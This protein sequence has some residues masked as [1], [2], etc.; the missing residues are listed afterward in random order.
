MLGAE[1]LLP[2]DSW[3]PPCKVEL[4]WSGNHA[5]HVRETHLT[6]IRLREEKQKSRLLEKYICPLNWGHPGTPPIPHI[7]K[8]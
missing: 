8:G 1:V 5:E 4:Q 2:K 6:G 3:H 7:G